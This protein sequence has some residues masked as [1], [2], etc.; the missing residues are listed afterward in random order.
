LADQR[1]EFVEDPAKFK[2]KRIDQFI[3]AEQDFVVRLK[4][5]VEL[6]NRKSLKRMPQKNSNVIRD[7]PRFLGT[8]QS[9][10]EKRY[11]V[12]FF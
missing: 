5:N 6:S 10:S 8:I 3:L 9:R 12:V 1:F 11:C 4:G 7:L 2:I